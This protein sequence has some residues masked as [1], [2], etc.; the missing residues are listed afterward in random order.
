[1]KPGEIKAARIA[2]FGTQDRAAKHFQVT[3]SAWCRWERGER[4]MPKFYAMELQKL[5]AHQK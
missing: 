2:I 1:M 5:T 4:K 3:R